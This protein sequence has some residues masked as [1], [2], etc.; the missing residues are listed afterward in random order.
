MAAGV[1]SPVGL[2]PD[3]SLSRPMTRF[4]PG[5]SAL[6]LSR[7]GFHLLHQ[8]SSPQAR[9]SSAALARPARLEVALDLRVGAPFEPAVEQSHRGRPIG[10]RRRP[11][12]GLEAP[13]EGVEVRLARRADLDVIL[14]RLAR[15]RPRVP[16]TSRLRTDWSGHAIGRGLPSSS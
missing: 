6:R 11:R 4:S 2:E 9:S 5:D 12:R 13:V 14:D 7:R 15:V 8:G 10:T 16:S 3:S 1:N